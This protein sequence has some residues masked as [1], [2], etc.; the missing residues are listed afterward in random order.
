[1]PQRRIIRAVRWF[2]NLQIGAGGSGFVY[3][4]LSP[5]A[6]AAASAIFPQGVRT[7]LLW[8]LCIAG[9]PASAYSGTNFQDFIWMEVNPNQNLYA[10]F[11]TGANATGYFE[12]TLQF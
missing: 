10:S 9:A 6:N 3:C 8:S 2:I 7:E 1:M 11:T 5:L 4:V 12:C